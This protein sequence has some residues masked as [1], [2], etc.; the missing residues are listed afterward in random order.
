MAAVMIENNVT[1]DNNNLEIVNSVTFTC[2]FSPTLVVDNFTGN[3][4][5]GMKLKSN[6]VNNLLESE[7]TKNFTIDIFDTTGKLILTQM[8]MTGNQAI[9][10]ANY[11]NGLY[12]IKSIDDQNQHSTFKF[13]KN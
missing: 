3:Q 2:K 7:T 11:S 6:L 13:F 10:V 4:N 8:T 5:I 1:L 12:F 9:D